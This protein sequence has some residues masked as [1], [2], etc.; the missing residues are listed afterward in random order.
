[1]LSR[2]HSTALSIIASAMASASLL[3]TVPSG[4]VSAGAGAQI[5][6]AVLQEAAASAQAAGWTPASATAARPI[7]TPASTAV[8]PATPPPSAGMTDAE[9]QKLGLYLQK[10]EKQVP[11]DKPVADLWNLAKPG[12]TYYIRELSSHD[13]GDSQHSHYYC[14]GLNDPKTVIF[15]FVDRKTLTSHG[16]RTDPSFKYVSAYV[17]DGQIKKLS[18]ADGEAGLAG[19]LKWWAKT[20]DEAPN[21]P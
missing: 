6:P 13:D 2:K 16:Y 7:A 19:E 9:I 21:L 10:Y 11:V 5:M 20:M 17:W 1:M 3:G 18:T 4:S 8:A 12:E 15:I 14:I